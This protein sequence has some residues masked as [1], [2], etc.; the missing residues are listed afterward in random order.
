MAAGLSKTKWNGELNGESA[1]GLK[2]EVTLAYKGKQSEES[3]LNTV[4]SVPEIIWGDADASNRLYYGDNLPLLATLLADDT[5]RGQVRLIYID[6]PY[7][8]G[9]VFQSRAQT[10]AYTDLLDGARY[11]EF[12]RQRLILLRELLAENGSIYLHL[13]EKMAFHAKILMDEVF[14]RVN[15]RN[16][17]T[18]KKCNPKNYTRRTYGNVSDYILFYTKSDQYTWNRAIEPWT[19]ERAEKEYICVEPE[20]GR[21]FKKVPIHAAGTRKGETGKPWRGMLPPPGKHWQY[22]PARLDEMNAR[23]EIHWSTNGN[24]RRKIYLDQTAGVPL[25]DIWLDDKDAH[26]QNVRVTGYPTEKNPALLQRIIQASSNPDDLVLDCFAG[27]GTT[28]E[29][30][31]QLERRWIG[32]DNSPTAV[33]TI[34]K[35][36]LVG[37]E[38][39][40][41]FV[42]ATNPVQLELQTHLPFSEHNVMTNFALCADNLRALE[43][44][45]VVS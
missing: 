28:L 40:G 37:R 33:A 2:P 45:D 7:A 38:L 39:M 42:K 12:L 23:G 41:D 10:D 18:R 31:A 13:D 6:P 4:P 30:A 8:T 25:Q 5:I 36:L 26:N 34:L 29:V 9:S 1:N 44:K 17:I 27:S 19:T 22:T 24:P 43:L 11:L 20:T 3:V 14:G 32:I 35:R 15:Y 16:F 21:R